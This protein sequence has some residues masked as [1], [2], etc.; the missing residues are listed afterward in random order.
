MN[1]LKKA[2]KPNGRPKLTVLHNAKK[3]TGK[4]ILFNQYVCLL[5]GKETGMPTWYEYRR[6]PKGAA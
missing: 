2:D 1:T 3:E 4:V 6:I 5:P